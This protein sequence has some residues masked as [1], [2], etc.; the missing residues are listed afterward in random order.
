MYQAIVFLPLLGAVV[1]ALISLV[2]ARARHAGGEPAPG[3]EDHAAAPVAEDHPRAAPSPG[4]PHAALQASHGEPEQHAVAAVG[5][6]FAE[7]VTTGLLF[8]SLILS[9]IALAQVGLRHHAHVSVANW[10]AAGD[11]KFAWALRVDALTA[12]MLVVVT[13]ISALVH[14]YSIGYMKD[15]PHQPRFFSYLSL[16]TFAMLMLVRAAILVPLFF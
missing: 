15:D 13:T 7:L 6:I 10:V 1:A 11:L 12:V 8:F 16:F 9:W 3:A 2:G 14:L 4:A 5:S